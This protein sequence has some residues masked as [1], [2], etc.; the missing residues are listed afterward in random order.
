MVKNLGP[1]SKNVI[2]APKIIQNF[3][4]PMRGGKKDRQDMPEPDIGLAPKT[5]RGGSPAYLKGR[6]EASR[7]LP[8]HKF[9]KED[10][11]TFSKRIRKGAY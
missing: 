1:K 5:D 10:P 4:Y 2:Q 8:S 6:A 7:A 11:V 9:R 3:H